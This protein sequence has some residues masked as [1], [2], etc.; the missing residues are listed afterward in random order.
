MPEERELMSLF[1]VQ[2]RT[3]EQ[4]SA[5]VF[6]CEEFGDGSSSPVHARYSVA[7]LPQ[8]CACDLCGRSARVIPADCY[9]LRG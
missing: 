8:G 4:Q 9:G 2:R 6:E 3:N 1:C 5:E 7:N